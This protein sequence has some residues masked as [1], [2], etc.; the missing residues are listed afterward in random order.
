M[1]PAI[2]DDDMSDGSND[3]D[4]V[5]RRDKKAAHSDDEDDE[6]DFKEATNGA[7]VEEEEEEGDEGEEEEYVVE[8]ILSHRIDESDG[9]LR[10]EVKWEG[11]E[12]KS[13][14]TW[15]PL[16]NLQGSADEIL[17]EYLQEHGTV[18]ELYESFS[19]ATK[20]KKRGRPSAG[21]TPGST[22]KSRKNGDHPLDSEPPE[23]RKAVAWKPPS[24][25]WEDQIDTVD[26]TRN[27]KGELI[28]W[29]GWKNGEKSQHKAQQAYTRAPQKML[30]FYESKINF[31]SS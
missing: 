11:F 23:S 12:K 13:D 16:E 29:L 6:D 21:A 28:V 10:F 22:K 25:S 19:K 17:D 9:K 1:P 20:T 18:A 2:S 4:V 26:M 31:T 24:G 27:D 5:P 30:K 3:L 14:R 15:E 7:A 8:K